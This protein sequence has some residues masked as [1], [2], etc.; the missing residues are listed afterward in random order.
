MKKKKIIA[1][2]IAVAAA[3]T[4]AFFIVRF[5]N[6]GS[7]ASKESVYVQSVNSINAADSCAV[8]R[9]SGVVETQ[10]S[11]TV[12]FDTSLTL[13][14]CY[15]AQGDQVK[16]GD[17]LFSYSTESTQLEIQQKELSIEKLNSTIS[18]DNAQITSLTEQMNNV[19][20][21]S[22]IEYSSQILEL[23]TEVSQSEYDIKVAQAEIDKLKK[24]VEN[25]TITADMD[26][27]ITKLNDVST[28]SEENK[29]YMT[30][31]AA[32]EYRVKGRV[33]ESNITDISENEKVILRSRV[34]DQKTW[35]GTVSSIETKA[36]TDS[37]SGSE[38]A[39][40]ASSNYAF[41]VEL[42][43]TDG[44]MLGQHLTIEKDTG[45]SNLSGIW[46]SGGWISTEGE[47]S[48]CWAA[49]SPDGRLEKR[50]ITLGEYKE[51]LDLYEVTEGLSQG[52]YLAWPDSENAA[53][54]KVMVSSSEG[55]QTGEV[56]E[57]SSIEES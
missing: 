27:E 30:I 14:E 53:G 23:Q 17:K 52:D 48:Y 16:T 42:D 22:K 21:D 2:V 19:S 55:A 4:A 5:V 35:T 46:I 49:S 44:L 43:N 41:Y 47:K 54:M 45:Y 29:T 51:D 15:V 25:A 37:S 3:A 18:N 12:E 33:N 20:A 39:T 7:N 38:A 8:N 56:S 26:G 1:V 10:K 24:K 31:T 13:N 9:F 6:A 11:E 32:G 34:D 36:Q 28:L 57:I 40:D 50:E